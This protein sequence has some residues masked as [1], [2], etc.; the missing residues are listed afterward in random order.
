LR[1]PLG[2]MENAKKEIASSNDDNQTPKITDFGY[3]YLSQQ[4]NSLMQMQ[5]EFRNNMEIRFDNLRLEIKS[6]IKNLSDKT[7]AKFDEISKENKSLSDKTDTKFEALSNKTSANINALSDKINVKFDEVNKDIKNLSD[8]TDTKFN[9][10]DLKINA[11][12]DKTDTRFDKV[13]LDIKETRKEINGLQR[14]AFA[15][16]ITVI[17]GFV[18]IYLK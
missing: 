6:E 13:D 18:T 11:L 16:I 9:A 17:I 3:L 10:L 14:W 12:S 4:I 15:L 2:D 5:N 8:K 7:Y 1:M